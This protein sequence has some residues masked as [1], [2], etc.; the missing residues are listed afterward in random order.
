MDKMK[1]SSRALKIA[2]SRMPILSKKITG[3]GKPYEKL[4]LE[5]LK[6]DADGNEPFPTDKAIMQ[7]LDIKPVLYRKWMHQIYADLV[8]ML[9]DEHNPGLVVNKLEHHI[10]CNEQD[11]KFYFVT[12]LPETPRVGS[13][14]YVDFFYPVYWGD[15]FYVDNVWYRLQ[16]GKM[17]VVIY[18]RT[19]FCNEYVKFKEEQEEYEAW[20]KGS[21][22]WW[23]WIKK[24]NGDL[25]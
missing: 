24:K 9:E 13:S 1:Y 20:K 11:K 25:S 15:H 6:L 18:L 23:E 8:E 22:Y 17:I 3:I 16:D 10:S 2:I 5:I 4:L 21:Y 7:N 19:N 14:F 12:T